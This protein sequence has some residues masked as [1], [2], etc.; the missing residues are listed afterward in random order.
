[1]FCILHHNSPFEKYLTL[2]ATS[3]WKPFKPLDFVL[4]AQKIGIPSQLE[5]GRLLDLNFC[6]FRIYLLLDHYDVTMEIQLNKFKHSVF[7]SK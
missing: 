2:E 7:L 6:I 4:R 5:P 3:S 1:M